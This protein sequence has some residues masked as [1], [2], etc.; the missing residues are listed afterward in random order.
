MA[1]C[2]IKLRHEMNTELLMGKLGKCTEMKRADNLRSILILRKQVDW[3]RTELDHDRVQW[4]ALV[5]GLAEFSGS[6]LHHNGKGME[7][8][9]YLN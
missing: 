6:Y 2:I 3:K 7:K 5:L 8:S 4:W 9:Q 1:K